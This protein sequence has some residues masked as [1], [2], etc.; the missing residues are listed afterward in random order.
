[1]AGLLPASMRSVVDCLQ[2]KRIGFTEFVDLIEHLNAAP[3]GGV[4]DRLNALT[5]EEPGTNLYAQI[6]DL[7]AESVDEKSLAGVQP[8]QWIPGM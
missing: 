2:K 6:A 5:A 3:G 7:V 1:M 8:K 4:R